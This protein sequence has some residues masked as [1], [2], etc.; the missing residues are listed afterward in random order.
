MFAALDEDA[1]A[2]GAQVFADGWLNEHT[3]EYRGRPMD[4][5]FPPD[6]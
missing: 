5:E 6:G 4:I 2:A 3:G 1:N